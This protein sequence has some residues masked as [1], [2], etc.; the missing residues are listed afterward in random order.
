LLPENQGNWNT[1]YKSFARWCEHQVWEDML[2][3]F[4]NDPDMENILLDSSIVRAHPCAQAR[5]KK[6]VGRKARHS[7]AAGVVSAR[8]SMPV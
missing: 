3:H 4:T 2:Q 1:V 8:K 5:P 6:T 7:G